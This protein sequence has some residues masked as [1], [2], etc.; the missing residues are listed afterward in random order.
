M[1]G[2]L[3]TVVGVIGGVSAISTLTK[4][5]ILQKTQKIDKFKNYYNISN[6][7]LVL[8]QEGKSLEQFFID[9]KYK[10]VAIYGMGELG[11]RLY[12][13]LKDSNN[14]QVK[15]AI[16]RNAASTYAEIEILELEAG[17]PE[18]D[19]IVVTAVFAFDEI[20]EELKKKVECQIVS[21]NDVVWEV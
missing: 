19:V 15:Y 13:E 18:V 14:I 4:K 9:N 10:T 21:L 8:K 5:Q 11:N 2:I 17:L 20:E 1:V 16:D 3:G 7:W 6:Q 12:D